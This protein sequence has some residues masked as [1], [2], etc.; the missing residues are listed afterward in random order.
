MTT[1]AYILIFGLL[2]SLLASVVYG[3]YWA[4]R[5]GQFSSFQ[6]GATCIFDED[7]PMGYRTDAWPPGK[8]R[9]SGETPIR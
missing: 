2:F 6:K 7:E 1:I 9:K 8:Q 3:L 4:V 5:K